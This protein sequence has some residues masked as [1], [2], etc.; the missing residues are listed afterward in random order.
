MGRKKIVIR[1]SFEDS[2]QLSL[3][4]EIEGPKYTKEQQE[5][6]TYNGD[7]SVILAATAGSG[8]THSS[9]HRLKELL[10][11]GVDPSKII[12]FSFTKAATEEL[13]KRIGTDAIKITTIHAYCLGVLA[14]VGKFKKIITF[15]DFIQ[16]FQEKY[17]PKPG[18]TSEERDFYYETIGT[19]YED[20]SYLESA[21]AS[22]KLQ[23]ADGIK[24]L[25]PTYLS[26]YNKF[27]RETKS[28]DFSDMLIEVR[29]LFRDD[30]WL[31]MFRNQYEY[32]FVDEYQDT[33]TIQLQILL[34]LNAKYYYMIGDRNQCVIAGAKI[35][36]NVGIKNIEEL[37]VGDMVLS[38]V[39]SNGLDYKKVTDCFKN[40]FIGEVIKIKT[41][42]GKE[43]TTTKEHT[44]FAKYVINEKELFFT[45]LMYKKGYGFRIGITR[46]YHN[47]SSDINGARFGFMNR[48]N[49]ENAQKIWLLEVSDTQ[50]DSKYWEEYYSITYRIPTIVFK[51]R[52]SEM[53]QEFIDKI[54]LN[55]NSEVG[56]INLLKYKNYDL[57]TPHHFPKS[58]GELSDRNINICLCSDGREKISIHRIEIGGNSE[59][60]KEKLVKSGFIVQDNGKRTGWR[61]RKQSNN[62][63]ELI[64]IKNKFLSII[65]GIENKTVLLKQGNALAF[66]KASYLM[67]GMTV[68]VLNE[69]N[70]IEYDIIESVNIEKYE[71]FV[72]DINV[73]NTHNFIAN[74]IFTHNSIYG[75]SGAN[76]GQLEQLLKERRETI[77][78]SL[79][80]NFRSDKKIVEN[81]NKFSNLKAVANSQEEGFVDENI[82]FTVDELTE[83]LKLPDEV[84]VLVR[85]NDVIKKLELFMLKKQIP[86]RYFNYITQSDIKYFNDGKIHQALKNK[87]LKLKDVFESDKDVI[88]FIERNKK[89]NKF[90]TSIHKSKGREF[91]V[92]VVVNSLP[93]ELLEKYPSYT[94]LSKKQLEKITFDPY[95]EENIEG[96]NVHYVAVSRARHKIYF[97]MMLFA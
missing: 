39:G 62:F 36:T 46:S 22:F 33:S 5:F 42:S 70:E 48:L 44:H 76:C 32:I 18:A 56:A 10:K 91:D 45:Y 86:M 55:I 16:W 69:K 92:T 2:P 77:D 67:K 54:F 20:T 13:Q 93:P 23:S 73:D 14:K 74:N 57:E 65:H 79:S 43:L 72:Y 60:D 96:R 97:M 88:H 11:R 29:D 19:L 81:S 24:S 90:I 52:G 71:G 61:I 59:E 89:S 58:T 31:K 25:I 41:K 12:F 63:K 35:H 47:R 87:L 37:N 50:Q 66:T 68:Y 94:K 9:V 38:G 15:Y 80:I 17:K 82:I 21:I 49:G 78:M 7:K 83:I 27:M 8:K 95:D 34:S 84:V 40:K 1:K 28:R 3:L 85:T 64:D 26:E 51:S 30:K 53:P 6:I 4:A 75:Y